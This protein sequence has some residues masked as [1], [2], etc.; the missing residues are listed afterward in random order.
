L[1]TPQFYPTYGGAEQRYRRYLPGLRDSGLDVMVFAGTAT[2][3][4]VTRGDALNQKW[5]AHPVG[6]M[7]PLETINGSPVFRLRLPSRKGPRRRWMFSQRL[8]S[9]C[10][11]PATRPDVVQ[12]L[13]T[14][15]V[16]AVPWVKRLQGL[17]IPTLYSVTTASKIVRKKRFF[18]TR[19]MKFR[20]LFSAMDAVVT[21]SAAV[22]DAL[23]EMGVSSRIEVIPNGV[24]IE[25]FRPAPSQE[26]RR[27]VRA[28]LELG[29]D[30]QLV[31]AIGAVMARKGSDLLLDAFLRVARDN[32]YA[33]LLFVGPRYDLAQTE[34]SDFQESMAKLLC[35]PLAADRVHF[36]GIV[37]DVPRYLQAA[38]L[39]VLASRLEGM[40]NS[41][42]EAMACAV[43]VLMTP[44]TGMS[45]D[46]GRPQREFLLCERN[47]DALTDAMVSLLDDPAGR[48]SLAHA[49]RRWVE[50]RLPLDLSVKRHVDLYKDLVTA[51]RAR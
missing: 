11:D 39:C 35:D 5:K 50:D 27:S 15:R 31:I 13:G 4:M 8:D 1:A 3:E 29:A 48:S 12:L 19:L 2:D 30:A 25:R 42:L 37:E 36:L 18:D 14:I 10:R 22:G 34:K 28:E 41:V 45:D 33:H 44:F 43:P 32:P 6:S 49:G 23:K 40:P 26:I 51:Y 24:D 46:L 9:F 38:D 21:N 17:G 7:L 20:A 47:T 16:G